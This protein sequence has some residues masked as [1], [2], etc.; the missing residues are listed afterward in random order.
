MAGGAV[1]TGTC[2]GASIYSNL[3]LAILVSGHASMDRSRSSASE[4]SRQRREVTYSGHVQGVGF[5]DAVRRLASDFRVTGYVRNLD[6][7]RVQLVGEGEADELTR[8][9]DAIA[10]RMARYIRRTA[11]DSRPATGELADFEIRL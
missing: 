9:L 10:A 6:D 8:F 5:R 7:G 11:V 1:K 4:N 2:L 3:R